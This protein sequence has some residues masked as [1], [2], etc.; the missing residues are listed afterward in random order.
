MK[1][2]TLILILAIFLGEVSAESGVYG[3][4]NDKN[5]PSIYQFDF[6]ENND[7]TYIHKGNKIIGVWEIGVWSVT[8]QTSNRGTCYIRVYADNA[9]CCF[10]SKF[11][12]N[13]LILTQLYTGGYTGEMCESRVLVRPK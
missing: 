6:A 4:W 10:D 2:L 1:K 13:N 12:A 5:K 8:T 9:E 11:I 7:F 3:K